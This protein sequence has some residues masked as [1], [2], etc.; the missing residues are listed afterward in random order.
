MIHQDKRTAQPTVW[1]RAT[2]NRGHTHGPFNLLTLVIHQDKSTCPKHLKFGV[3][4]PLT[5][6]VPSDLAQPCEH[7]LL[8]HKNDMKHNNR[9]NKN[10]GLTSKVQNRNN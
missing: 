9:Q 4:Q 10:T 7:P 6:D 3:K 2:I 5:E 8:L 1:V